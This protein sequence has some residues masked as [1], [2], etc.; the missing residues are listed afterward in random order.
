MIVNIGKSKKYDNFVD[1]NGFFRLI[2]ITANNLDSHP[3]LYLLN[4]N[5][6]LKL[7]NSVNNKNRTVTDFNINHHTHTNTPFNEFSPNEIDKN[8]RY[9]DSVKTE[10]EMNN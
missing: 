3:S 4:K 9:R 7:S 1:I 8:K 5:K 6:S 10:R 2:E